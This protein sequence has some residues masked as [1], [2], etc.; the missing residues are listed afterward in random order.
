MVYRLLLV[1]S[2]LVSMAMPS[3]AGS[4]LSG[5]EIRNLAPG[6]YVG[7]WKGKR[8]LHISLKQNGTVSG[9]IDGRR[10]S[11]KWY[12]AGDNL[13]LVFKV[14]MFQKTKCGSITRQGSWL[15]GYYKEGKPRVRLKAA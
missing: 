5:S 1:L 14:M 6:F 13:C 10:Y 3:Q 9:S 8:K 4:K 7:T 15:V 11:G 12:V 2:L